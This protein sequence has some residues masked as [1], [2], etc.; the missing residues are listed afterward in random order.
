MS[1]RANVGQEKIEKTLSNYF[2]CYFW[3]ILGMHSLN[4]FF[5][6]FHTLDTEDSEETRRYELGR[7]GYMTFFFLLFLIQIGTFIWALILYIRLAIFLKPRSES[8][9]NDESDDAFF[10]DNGQI[11]FEDKRNQIR[12]SFRPKYAGMIGHFIYFFVILTVRTCIY[13]YQRLAS[14]EKLFDWV[15]I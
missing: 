6:I 10:Q 9:L 8:E 2:C 3:G 13:S 14:K 15:F 7:I 12:E 11:N 1:F 4:L 5:I